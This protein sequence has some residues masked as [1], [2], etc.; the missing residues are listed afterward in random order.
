M[1]KPAILALL[2]LAVGCDTLLDPPA[3]NGSGH[4]RIAVD[5]SGFERWTGSGQVGLRATVEN[6]S[7]RDFHAL[8]GDGFNSAPEQENVFAALGTSA[9]V[10]RF[11]GTR[12]ADA[13]SSALVEGSR[14]V[15]LRSGRSYTLLAATRDEPGVYRIRFGYSAMN[16]DAS[17][18]LPL[19]DYSPGFTIK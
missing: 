1:K 7:E 11:D 4:F 3:G 15:V 10:E 5:P 12:W 18:P 8:V 2:T 19:V 17:R 16:N 14:Y 13:T 9:A 6:V